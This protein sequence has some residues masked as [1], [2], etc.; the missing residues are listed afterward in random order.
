MQYQ[1]PLFHRHIDLVHFWCE[2][3][4]EKGDVV[5][6]ATCGNGN[7]TLF[8]AQRVL[9]ENAGMIWAFDLQEIALKNTK[10]KL[11][12]HF[13]L[14]W[15]ERVHF[16]HGSHD[17]LPAALLEKRVKLAVYNLGYLPGSDK[18]VTTLPL[19]TIASLKGVSEII[20]EGGVLCVTC[21]SGHPGG[22]EEQERVVEWAS[23]L[24]KEQWNVCFHQWINMRTA[25]ALL[26]IQRGTGKD[27]S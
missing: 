4:L 25:P 7:D 13:P 17:R 19:S 3:I 18:S 14:E 10:E 8:L 12:Q 5:I 16:V 21:Y 15:L 20:A 11:Q 23:T 22:K 6:D 1:F 24:P 26:L 2:K 9:D 27:H